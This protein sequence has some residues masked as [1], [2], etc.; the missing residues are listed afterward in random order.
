MASGQGHGS[1]SLSMKFIRFLIILFNITFVVVGIVL[2]AVGIYVIRDPKLQQLRPLLSP[3][4]TATYSET[5]S[6]V[7]IFAIILLVV[8]SVLIF[9]GFLGTK[10][11]HLFQRR[12]LFVFFQVVVV[13]SKVFD[14]YICSMRS[15]SVSLLSQKFH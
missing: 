6:N 3:D 4:I 5:L 14:V 2:L 1:M 10:R 15:S 12:I 7:Q 9:I 8:G 11:K 13:H